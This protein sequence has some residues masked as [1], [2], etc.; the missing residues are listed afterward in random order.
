M[1]STSTLPTLIDSL[2][3]SSY[4][5]NRQL[6]PSVT[7]EQWSAIFGERTAIL[8]RRYQDECRSEFERVLAGTVRS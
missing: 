6:T 1:T 2:T 5:H 7:P 8:E 3:Y 4:A